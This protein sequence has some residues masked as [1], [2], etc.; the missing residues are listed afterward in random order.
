MHERL[1]HLVG[2]FIWNVWWCTDLQT[3]NCICS[4]VIS[5]RRV[6]LS[7]CLCDLVLAANSFLELLRNLSLESLTKFVQQGEFWENRFVESRTSFKDVRELLT[8]FSEIHEGAGRILYIT[9]LNLCQFLENL[10]LLKGPNYILRVLYIFSSNFRH[11]AVQ[12]TATQ[13]F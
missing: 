2:W 6:C 12:I 1:L 4:V 11:T 5:Y 10:P 3:L 8:V 9:A 13:M 7:V